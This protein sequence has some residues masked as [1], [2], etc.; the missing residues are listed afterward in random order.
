MDRRYYH[1]IESATEAVQ[2]S[3]QIAKNADFEEAVDVET[4]C[5]LGDAC[6]KMM[7]LRTMLQEIIKRQIQA[8]ERHSGI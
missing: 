4:Q 8:H 5:Y 3:T 6:R 2:M 1:L 7:Q